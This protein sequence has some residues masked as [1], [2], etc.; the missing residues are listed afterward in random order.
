M[1]IRPRTGLT[2]ITKLDVTGDRYRWQNKRE[3]IVNLN[4]PI[5]A[6]STTPSK[7]GDEFVLDLK[8][9]TVVAILYPTPVEQ[10][11]SCKR[12]VP[13]GTLEKVCPGCGFK[14]CKECIDYAHTLP[15]LDGPDY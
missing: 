2:L 6:T 13:K 3:I 1:R 4:G 11:D 10:C 12:W 7:S 5:V 14:V 15:D 9:Q 8:H